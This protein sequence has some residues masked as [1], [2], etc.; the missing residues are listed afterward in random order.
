MALIMSLVLEHEF[1]ESGTSVWIWD[2]AQSTS[3]SPSPG[4]QER[5]IE[6]VQGQAGTAKDRKPRTADVQGNWC[7]SQE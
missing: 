5:G 7:Q 6:Q 1:M 4:L 2:L 3:L